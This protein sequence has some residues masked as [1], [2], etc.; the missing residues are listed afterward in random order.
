M[1]VELKIL[2][3]IGENN[4]NITQRDISAKTDISLGAINVL[5]KKMIEKGFIKI[6]KL[7][8]RTVRY[9]LTPKGMMEK[10]KKTYDYVKHSYENIIKM[11][12]ELESIV[13][14]LPD[15]STLYLYGEEDEVCNMITLLL[16]EIVSFRGILLK[17]VSLADTDRLEREDT[18]IIWSESDKDKLSEF[19]CINI[20]DRIL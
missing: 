15:N 3:I 8:T 19:R 9:M 13:L 7:S 18:V 17:K 14:C 12:N 10:A 4:P 6:E 11:K 20:L 2:S 16:N 5:L 1:E